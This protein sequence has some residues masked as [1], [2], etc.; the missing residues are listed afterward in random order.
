MDSLL[1]CSGVEVAQ[2]H[3]ACHVPTRVSVRS[4]R[5]ERPVTRLTMGSLKTNSSDGTYAR[6]QSWLKP[7]LTLPLSIDSL[8][9]FLIPFNGPSLCPH[10]TTRWFSEYSLEGMG[11]S[12]VWIPYCPIIAWAISSALSTRRIGFIPIEA[13]YSW[14][15]GLC[16]MWHRH[17]PRAVYLEAGC[18]LS[19]TGN[20]LLLG[21]ACTLWATGSYTAIRGTYDLIKQ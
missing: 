13:Q 1:F 15:I 2:E 17:L 6:T 10:G 14:D 20:R 8:Q 7:C 4:H 11:F 18:H 12:M 5:A 16:V 21:K 19:E 3:A 9:N